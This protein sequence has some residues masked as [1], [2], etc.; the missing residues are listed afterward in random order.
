MNKPELLAALN[1]KYY[2]VFPLA[3][4]ITTYGSNLKYY[5]AIVFDEVGDVLRQREVYFYVE[6][7]GEANEVAHWDGSEPKKTPVEPPVTFRDEVNT[8]IQVKIDAGA[9]EGAF[10]E[11]VD[12]VKEIAYGKAIIDVSGNLMEKIIFVDKDASGNMQHRVI[13]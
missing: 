3:R 2:L 12:S 11:D 8:Y 13:G 7:E 10:V 9:I 6:N 1:T 4:D 5:K